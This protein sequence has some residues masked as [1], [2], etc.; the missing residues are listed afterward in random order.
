MPGLQERVQDTPED[1][2]NALPMIHDMDVP[3]QL[4]SNEASMEE[5]PTKYSTFRYPS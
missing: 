4:L 1:I 5:I 3:Q 2:Q